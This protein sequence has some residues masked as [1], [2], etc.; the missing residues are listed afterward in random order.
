MDPCAESSCKNDTSLQPVDQN[1]GGTSERGQ[2]QVTQNN[3]SG[4]ITS[5]ECTGGILK[6]VPSDNDVSI[7]RLQSR[8]RDA[9]RLLIMIC[10][11][12]QMDADYWFLTDLGANITDT[13][14]TEGIQ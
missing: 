12:L 5:Q 3:C 2:D 1:T 9:N 13:W 11:S 10:L 7:Q 6:I 8:A 14:R 4:S